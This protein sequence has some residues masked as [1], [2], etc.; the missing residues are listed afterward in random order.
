MMAGLD[1]PLQVI[2]QQLA[3]AID[4]IVQVSRLRDGTRK[5][6]SITEVAGMEGD[7]VVMTEIFKFEQ[8]GISED[9]KVLGDLNPPASARCLSTN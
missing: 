7:T 1:L 2:R 8:T 6:T 9:N 4:L 3:A 5:V